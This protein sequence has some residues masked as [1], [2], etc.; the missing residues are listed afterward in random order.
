MFR[1]IGVA[2]ALVVFGLFI[3]LG[4]SVFAQT[5]RPSTTPNT[6]SRPNTTNT[7]SISEIDRQYILTAAEAGLANIAMGELALQRA[8][9]NPVKQFAQ[10]EIDEQI[11][12]KNQLTRIAPRAGVTLPTAPGPKFQAALRRLSQISGE[13]FNQAYMSEGGVNAHLENAATFQREAAFGQNPDLVNLANSGLTIINQ[14][15]NTA[16]ALTNYRFAQ[17]PQRFNE[18]AAAPSN[19]ASSRSSQTVTPSSPNMSVPR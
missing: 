16:S 6:P 14:H 1:K 11:N 19:P 8:T 2:I 10:A 13:Q 18:R 15:F 3:A 9:S 4:S 12:V 5:G 17:V 7:I